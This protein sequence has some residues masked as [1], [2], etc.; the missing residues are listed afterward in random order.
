ME[1]LAPATVLVLPW[2]KKTGGGGGGAIM[3]AGG[4]KTEGEGEEGGPASSDVTVLNFSSSSADPDLVC[5]K[6]KSEQW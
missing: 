1:A 6:Q 3:G 5:R 2:A 4:G